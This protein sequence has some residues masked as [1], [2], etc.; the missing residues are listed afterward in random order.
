MSSGS[1]EQGALAFSNVVR[2]VAPASAWLPAAHPAPRLRQPFR[3]MGVPPSYLPNQPALRLNPGQLFRIRAGF[4]WLV[5]IDRSRLP[6]FLGLIANCQ[7]G[8]DLP[9]HWDTT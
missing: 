5:G 1:L 7:A 9:R 6:L 2:A 4:G 8:R 3:G